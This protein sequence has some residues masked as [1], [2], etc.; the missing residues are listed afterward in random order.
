M[1]EELSALLVLDGHATRQKKMK[2]W[3]A[4]LGGRRRT[5]YSVGDLDGFWSALVRRRSKRPCTEDDG[6]KDVF[7]LLFTGCTYWGSR[8]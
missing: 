5:D 1:G 3:T 6:T 7:L 4:W 8:R 2:D